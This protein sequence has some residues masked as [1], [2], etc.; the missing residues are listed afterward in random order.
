MKR[1]LAVAALVLFTPL[2]GS[3]QALAPAD[4]ADFVGTWTLALESPQG[5]FEQTLVVKDDAGKVVAEISSQMA[6]DV[7]KIT[8]VTKSGTNLVLK[9]QGNYQGNAFDA[10]ITVTPD[11]AD[12]A[13]IMF[14]VN[15][16]QF[17]M[18]GTGSRTKKTGN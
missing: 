18:A 7:Q 12:N 3:A 14:D 6:P 9:F 5:S 10:A 16:G 1:I 15:G 13:K 4:A 8:D 17:T 11:G 2:I